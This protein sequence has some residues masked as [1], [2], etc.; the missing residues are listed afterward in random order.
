[1]VRSFGVEKSDVSAHSGRSSKSRAASPRPAQQMAPTITVTWNSPEKL[2]APAF[3]AKTRR[4]A[5]EVEQILAGESKGNKKDESVLVEFDK[6]YK[7]LKEDD[8]VVSLD[9]PT[10]RA[11]FNGTVVAIQ[12]RIDNMKKQPDKEF[13]KYYEKCMGEIREFKE[14]ERGG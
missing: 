6:L 12:E 10:L 7:A 2:T 8:E 13:G 5:Y 9:A 11:A 3:L 4:L 14:K 1:M